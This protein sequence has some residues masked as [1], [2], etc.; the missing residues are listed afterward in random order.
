MNNNE[1]TNSGSSNSNYWAALNKELT[2][3]NKEFESKFLKPSDWDD[4]ECHTLT[5]TSWKPHESNVAGR[6][7]PSAWIIV[8]HIDGVECKPP[9]RLTPY[10]RQLEALLPILAK[11][12]PVQQV[13]VKLTLFR[14]ETGENTK[15]NYSAVVVEPTNE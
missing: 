13:T 3:S 6:I 2:S 8:S 9:K 7:R 12:D 10:G 1:T 5:F 11:Y 15:K 4:K 14:G